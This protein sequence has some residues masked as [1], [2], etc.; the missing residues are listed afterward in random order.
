MSFSLAPVGAAG[1]SLLTAADITL[2]A[3]VLAGGTASVSITVPM[4]ATL[5]GQHLFGQW[6]AFDQATN[7]FGWVSSEGGDSLIGAT[8]FSPSALGGAVVSG[9]FGGPLVL[10]NLNNVATDGM[11]LTSPGGTAQSILQ[12]GARVA[13]DPVDLSLVANSTAV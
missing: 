12:T 8:G 9:A 2:I 5:S 13:C 11:R 4:T 3:P 10:T 6:F 1:C 7:L